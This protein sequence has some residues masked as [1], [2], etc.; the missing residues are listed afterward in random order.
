M[1]GQMFRS[2]GADGS[3][4]RRGFKDGRTD[5]FAVDAF[6]GRLRS[7]GDDDDDD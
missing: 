7:N 6:T 2:H 1:D 4:W 3:S 5:A